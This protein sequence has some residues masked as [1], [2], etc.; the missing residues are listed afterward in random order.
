MI[1]I[2]MEYKLALIINILVR[3]TCLQVIDI[4]GGKQPM[5]NEDNSVVL[6]FNGEIYNFQELRDELERQISALGFPNIDPIIAILQADVE[7]GFCV[8]CDVQELLL[9]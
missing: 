9:L 8:V 1:A 2:T 6:V 4:A 5:A 3:S 7:F